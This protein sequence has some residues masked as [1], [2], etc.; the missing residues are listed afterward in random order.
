[1]DSKQTAPDPAQAASGLEAGTIRKIVIAAVVVLVGVFGFFLWQAMQEEDQLARWDT[2]GAIR[3]KHEP[4]QDPLWE[5]PYGV[6]NAERTQYIRALEAFLDGDAKDSG[7][8]LTPHTRFLLAKTIA[9]HI[10]SNPGAMSEED[11][12]AWYAKAEKQLIAIRDQHP[13]F[14]TNWTMFGQEGFANL[15][16]RFLKWLEQNRAWEKEFQLKAMAPDDDVRVLV[17]TNRGDMLFG[18]YGQLAPTWTKTFLAKAAAGELDGTAF[19]E[20]REIGDAAAPGEYGFRAGAA[21]SRDVANFDAKTVKAASEDEPRGRAM[22]EEARNRI[23]FERGLVAAWHDGAD[24]YDTDSQL[25]VI[26]ARSPN[27]DYKYTPIGK[28]VDEGGIESLLT[29]DRI[30]GGMVWR[31]DET[32]RDDADYGTLLDWFQAPVTIVKVLVYENGT[33]RE[34]DAA[35][36]TRATI[37]DSER[38]LSTVKADRYKSEPPAKPVAPEKDDEGKGDGD[39]KAD[40]KKDDE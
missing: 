29:A 19:V 39:D 33:L 34:P 16:R 27:L 3:H 25:F 17:R 32:V 14:P 20:K 36:P 6:Y 30:F 40:P 8:A 7:D 12:D 11:R 15:T 13:D 26:T 38:A 24:E 37:E 22:P 23:P 18:V 10:L 5:N 9:D 28:L 2:L 31:E 4:E 21:T 35:A 1:M